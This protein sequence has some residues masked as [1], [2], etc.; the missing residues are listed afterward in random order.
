LAAFIGRV[1]GA[2]LIRK[3]VHAYQD[4]R[5]HKGFLEI[6]EELTADHQHE[7]ASQEKRRQLQALDFD[8]H[9]RSLAAL[10]RKEKR[11]LEITLLRESRVAGRVGREGESRGSVSVEFHRAAGE[12]LGAVFDQVAAAP[13]Q[14]APGIELSKE[15][16]KAVQEE[17]EEG[18]QGSSK[19]P[20][21]Q[22]NVVEDKPKRRRRRRRRR[23]RDIDRGR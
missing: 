13:N 16:A 11:S 9:Q 2:Q 21:N 18:K 19:G 20:K 1:T 12:P 7:R 6:R 22:A 3:K 23:D 4:R 14:A 5:R 15:F 17:K 10:E 8:R